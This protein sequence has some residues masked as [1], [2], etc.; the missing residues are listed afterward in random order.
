EGARPRRVEQAGG[1][2]LLQVV[3]RGS[4][5]GRE[6]RSHAGLVPVR[7]EPA[8]VVVMRLAALLVVRSGRED[9]P[10]LGAS[11]REAKQ[12]VVPAAFFKQGQDAR[13][14][15]GQKS[16]FPAAF[17]ADEEMVEDD[18]RCGT[19]EAPRLL[20]TGG[21]VTVEKGVQARGE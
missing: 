6:G 7:Q 18:G 5:A 14:E 12:G 9:R 21:E 16:G 11:E 10:G 17:R 19:D 20:D 3:A 13:P 4:Q 8:A 15:V 2:L 1:Q